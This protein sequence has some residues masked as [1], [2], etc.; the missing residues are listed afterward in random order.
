MELAE[1]RRKRL[2]E[3]RQILVGCPV[4]LLLFGAL[5]AGLYNALHGEIV[6][7]AVVLGLG[8]LG[9]AILV[10]KMYGARGPAEN[11]RVGAHE[12]K[13]S[14]CGAGVPLCAGDVLLECPFCRASLHLSDAAFD[15]SVVAAEDE[16]AKVNRAWK[17]IFGA[18]EGP[19]G[20]FGHMD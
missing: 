3:S 9:F 11:N 7:A 16:L 1:I 10:V 17:K 4:V 15:E 13:C 12:V 20:P 2:G 8:V 18:D 19:L 6:A 14:S 5:G